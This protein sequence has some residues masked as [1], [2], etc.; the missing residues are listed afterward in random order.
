MTS[1][2]PSQVKL[3][4]SS[5]RGDTAAYG[6]AIVVDRL[7]GLLLL[8]LLTTHMDR[9]AFGAWTQILTSSALLSNIIE[10]G[11]YHS[12]VQ[13]IPGA[14]RGDVRR[15][16]YG[17]VAITFVNGTIFALIC[18]IA[19]KPISQLLFA[20][21]AETTV[22]VSAGQYI[23][24]ECLFE[25]LVLAFLRADGRIGLCSV[26][27]ASKSV[28]RILLL[29]YGLAAGTDLPGLLWL[30]ALGNVALVILVYVIHVAPSL[31]G[32]ID[33]VG[34]GFWKK[35]IRHSGMIVLSGN[36]S[37]ANASLSRFFI[38]H[39]LGLSELG[40]Y[41]AN[42]SLATIVSV[43]ALVINFT[44]VP[45]VNSA[46]NSG[47]RARANAILSRATEFYLFTTVPIAIC[48]GLFYQPIAEILIRGNFSAGPMLAWTLIVSMVVLGLEQLLS[49]ATFIGGSQFSVVARS[50]A[51]VVN[52]AIV[53]LFMPI[54]GVAIAA[55]AASLSSIVVIG[56]SLVFLRKLG[57]F[58]FPWRSLAWIAV[59]SAAM[60]LVGTAV[61]AWQGPP[62]LGHAVIAGIAATLAYGLVD[63]L[64]PAS[65]ARTIMGQFLPL[66]S[67]RS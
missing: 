42:Y 33:K 54:G 48:V 25:I 27:Y 35:A 10:F 50:L 21:S 44:T 60:I 18:W 36:L 34:P 1:P 52:I 7:I 6:A 24:S 17:V 66:W 46:W 61:L 51:F 19:P 14:A 64:R 28:L 26:Y 37:W 20:T 41:S 67:A 15:I 39:L 9:S 5:I 49:F 16:L 30:L 22:V 63:V 43:T 55:V 11:F 4:G 29:W 57:G 23:V 40:L 13:Y 12:L 2:P 53:L 56:A 32:P 65:L 31:T 47:D 62:T 3:A 45:H 38:V 58:A 59:D 8:P